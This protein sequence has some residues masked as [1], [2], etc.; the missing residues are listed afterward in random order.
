VARLFDYYALLLGRILVG[1]FFLWNGILYALNL[2]DSSKAFSS[3]HIG[4]VDPTWIVIVVIALEVLG[5]ISIIVD[6]KMR[7]FSLALA[8]YFIVATVLFHSALQD[9]SA[10]NYFL[11]NMA[12]IGAL[13]YISATSG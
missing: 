8:L 4:G 6:W 7:Y 10:T 13:L 1:G 9:P 5:G 3:I 2:S 12:L 11:K